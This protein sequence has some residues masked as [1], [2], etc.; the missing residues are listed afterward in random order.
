MVNVRKMERLSKQERVKWC[1][2][3]SCQT[4]WRKTT[5]S[6]CYYL[7]PCLLNEY[8]HLFVEMNTYRYASLQAF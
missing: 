3:S 2:I 4:R 5:Q 7:K 1:L 6:I 8:L